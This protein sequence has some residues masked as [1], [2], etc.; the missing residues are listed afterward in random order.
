MKINRFFYVVAIV[1][2]MLLLVPAVALA[3]SGGGTGGLE[4]EGAGLAA[5]RGDIDVTVSGAGVLFVRD[6]A[7]DAVIEVTGT[8]VRRDLS[9][10]WIHYSGFN[11]EAHV[12][13]SQVLVALSGA[14]IHL[15]A[16][17]TGGYLLRGVGSYTVWGEGGEEIVREG[18]WT[19]DGVTGRTAPPSVEP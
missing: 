13:G 16:T 19:D 14:N 10:G 1:S 5:V 11:G 4:A 2:L 12:T 17:G 15:Y 8:G 9:N 3:Q 7:G 6:H 18:A